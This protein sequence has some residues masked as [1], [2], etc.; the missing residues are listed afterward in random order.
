[1]FMYPPLPQVS[2]TL[3]GFF[4]S[5]ARDYALGQFESN[6]P[7]RAPELRNLLGKLGCVLGWTHGNLV[8]V[9]MVW[10]VCEDKRIASDLG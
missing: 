4:A 6:M 1:M 7:T 2:A 8:R 10:E 3:G 5:V 9:A